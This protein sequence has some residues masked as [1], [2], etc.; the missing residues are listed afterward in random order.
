MFLVSGFRNT[1][2]QIAASF[3]PDGK[4]VISAS[5]DSQVSVWRCEEPRNTG[6]GKTTVITA[7]GYEHFPCKDVSVAIPWAWYHKR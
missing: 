2:S 7:R 3:T 1:S 6:T 5:E 4:Y